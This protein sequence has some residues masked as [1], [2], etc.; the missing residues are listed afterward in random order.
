M[1]APVDT[2]KPTKT[3]CQKEKNRIPLTQRNLADVSYSKCK[4]KLTNW[5]ERLEILAD[6]DPE[7]GQ[8][9]GR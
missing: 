9:A 1:I 7:H 8:A 4:S 5:P 3:P 6:C 2:R